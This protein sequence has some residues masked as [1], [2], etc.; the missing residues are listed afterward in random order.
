MMR[1]RSRSP[2]L[3]TGGVKTYEDMAGE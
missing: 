2:T 3:R 1:A